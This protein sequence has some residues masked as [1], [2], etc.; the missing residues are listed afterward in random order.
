VAVAGHGGADARCDLAQQ[1]V[2]DHV[3]VL[4][5]EPL[6][7]IDVD[8][9]Q[10]GREV[11]GGSAH[12][13]R[14]IEHAGHRIDAGAMRHDAQPVLDEDLRIVG[15]ADVVAFAQG[16]EDRRELAGADPVQHQGADHL[17]RDE[18]VVDG[19]EVLAAQNHDC[20]IGHAARR[21]LLRAA[22]RPAA[23]RWTNRV[24]G[25]RKLAILGG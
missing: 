14:A 8:G 11:G 25:P 1:L 16:R 22:S 10:R 9:Q 23:D 2:T 13:A 6:E 4:I 3:V 24:P 19:P 17:A 20:R 12:E 21:I 15:E 18:H 5:V 7:P